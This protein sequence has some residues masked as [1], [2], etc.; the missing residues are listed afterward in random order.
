MRGR[1]AAPGPAADPEPQPATGRR[2][3]LQRDALHRMRRRREENQECLGGKPEPRRDAEAAHQQHVRKYP[4]E[5]P[6]SVWQ[7]AF[8]S[9]AGGTLADQERPAAIRN[10]SARVSGDRRSSA[11]FFRARRGRNAAAGTARNRKHAR[12]ARI[13]RL[14]RNDSEI[15]VY[16]ARH[17]RAQVLL[18]ESRR[19]R[20]GRRVLRH[21][22]PGWLRRTPENPFRT[23]RSPISSASRA[24]WSRGAPSP[25]TGSRCRFLRSA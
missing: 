7:P 18:R 23:A 17:F 5:Q 3:L 10:D 15:H 8:A 12:P 13:D 21:R 2:V 19:H 25:S 14:A 1:R 22:H 6:E 24:S 9:T 16:A 4:A 20:D 11:P